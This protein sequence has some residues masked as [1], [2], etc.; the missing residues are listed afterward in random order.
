M[1]WSWNGM[2]MGTRIL[3]LKGKYMKDFDVQ[4]RQRSGSNSVESV[5]CAESGGG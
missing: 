4:V 3:T 2:S 1:W 5:Y